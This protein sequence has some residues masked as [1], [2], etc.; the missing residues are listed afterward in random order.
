MAPPAT[1][2]VRSP[3]R[4]HL[5]AATNIGDDQDGSGARKHRHFLSHR[6]DYVRLCF[7]RL[8]ADVRLR[9]LVRKK[10]GLMYSLAYRTGSSTVLRKM[11]IC[12]A[13]DHRPRFT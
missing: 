12:I 13:S 10:C 9:S 4:T 11:I 2:Q 8:K 5:V 1:H 3:L 7:R 6:I